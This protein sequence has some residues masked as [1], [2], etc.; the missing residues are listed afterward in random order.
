MGLLAGFM[1]GAG[2][3][4]VSASKMAW[5]DQRGRAS[6]ERAEKR[7]LAVEGRAEQRGLAAE[8]RANAERR[9]ILRDTAKMASEFDREDMLE[10]QKALAASGG[11]TAKALGLA[12]SQGARAIIGQ[13]ASAED[14]QR[15]E[16]FEREKFNFER[17]DKDRSHNLRVEELRSRGGELGIKDEVKLNEDGTFSVYSHKDGTSKRV[18]THEHALR[19]AEA[20][21]DAWAEEESKGIFNKKPSDKAIEKKKNERYNEKMG[22][23]GLISQST[24]AGDPGDVFERASQSMA[25]K[26]DNSP[27]IDDEAARISAEIDSG[28]KVL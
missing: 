8:G 7:G 2:Q 11:D 5:E 19:E 13:I 23:Q 6:E 24:Q 20:E 17:G 25:G 27:K 15:G 28:R 14:K 1:G 3:G 18:Y 12:G 16:A 26:K 21:A 10:A 22:G 4:L 9:D